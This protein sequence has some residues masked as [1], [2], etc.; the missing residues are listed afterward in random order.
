MRS[1]KALISLHML[2][3]LDAVQCDQFQNHTCMLNHCVVYSITCVKRPLSKRPKTSFQDQLSLNAGLKYCR[4]LQ[5]EHSAILRPSLTY[6]LSFLIFVL[7]IFEWPFYTDF[8]VLVQNNK[9]MCLWMYYS[10][11]RGTDETCNNL[12]VAILLNNGIYS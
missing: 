5:G 1:A 2:R 4:M 9:H 6:H 3:R 12:H 8:T 7:Y 10:I 11:H